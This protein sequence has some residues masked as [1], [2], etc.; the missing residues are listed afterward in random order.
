[1]HEQ[2]IAIFCICEELVKFYGL[3][4]DL[5]CKMSTSE[6]MTLALISALHYRCDYRL[7][8]LVSQHL[9]YFSAMLS[10]SRLIRRIHAIPEEMWWIVF[11]SLQL[12]LKNKRKK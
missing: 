7:T 4:D 3:I 9:K 6:V 8:R 1:M 2:A 12:F 5:Q 10:Y 11:K